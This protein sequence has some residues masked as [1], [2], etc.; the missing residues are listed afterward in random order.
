MQTKLPAE[1]SAASRKQLPQTSVEAAGEL[2][3]VGRGRSRVYSRAAD[4]G[5]DWPTLVCEV[6]GKD[7]RSC[8]PAAR[9]RGMGRGEGTRD[10]ASVW[11]CVDLRVVLT[12]R[13]AVGWKRTQ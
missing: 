10:V 5:V 12:A 7:L 6:S 4:S 13:C 11:V 9:V 3:E 2:P 1:E 8:K